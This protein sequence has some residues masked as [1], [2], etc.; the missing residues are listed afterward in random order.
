VSFMIILVGKKCSFCC[1]FRGNVD[2][3]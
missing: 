3:Q 2:S 1:Q